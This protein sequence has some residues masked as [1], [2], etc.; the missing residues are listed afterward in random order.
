MSCRVVLSDR[1]DDAKWVHDN[2]YAYN[3]EKTGEPRQE[4]ILAQ[5][6]DRKTFLAVNEAGERLGGCCWH[7]RREKQYL[8]VDFLWMSDA[9]RGTGCGSALIQAVETQARELN[10]LGIELGTNTF[11]S[12]GFYQKMGFL[13]V[14]EKKFPVRNYPENIH[15]TFRKTF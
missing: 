4:I 8:F 15:Y 6:P 13:P 11:Q 10:C 5:D 9:A 7:V 1:Y 14:G 12:P 3:L 2:L